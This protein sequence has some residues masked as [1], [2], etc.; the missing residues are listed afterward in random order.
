MP[1][2]KAL[3]LSRAAEAF[4]EARNEKAVADVNL[5]KVF[6]SFLLVEGG[7]RRILRTR[8]HDRLL[9]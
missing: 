5:L 8:L 1:S 7:R 2:L 3:L 9:S 4:C 6:E